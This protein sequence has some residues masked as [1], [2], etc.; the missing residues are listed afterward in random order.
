MDYLA[1]KLI[2]KGENT[3]ALRPDTSFQYAQLALI[4]M[5]QHIIFQKVLLSHFFNKCP[6]LVHKI[7]N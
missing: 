3:V 5:K 7:Q 2:E 4:V 6:Y 1:R